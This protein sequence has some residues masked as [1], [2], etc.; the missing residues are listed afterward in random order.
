MP[1]NQAAA[2]NTWWSGKSLFP[3]M[4][5]G[6][7]AISRNVA[8]FPH[9]VTSKRSILKATVAR[10]T[11][12]PTNTSLMSTSQQ[13]HSGADLSMMPAMAERVSALWRP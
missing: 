12:P 7:A 1:T 4:N 9:Q 3:I 8:V 10:A 5:Q 11:V 13:N 6:N 2:V